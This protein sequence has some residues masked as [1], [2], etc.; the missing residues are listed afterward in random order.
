[1]LGRLFIVCILSAL[2][3]R[4]ISDSCMTD[5]TCHFLSDNLFVDWLLCLVCTLSS[6]T[7]M[8]PHRAS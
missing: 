2:G 3:V 4:E 8:F 5:S 6:H 7:L 1:M